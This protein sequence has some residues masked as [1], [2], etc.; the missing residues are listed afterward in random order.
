MEEMPM[1]KM[2]EAA[3]ENIKKVADANT[4]IG[5]PI[6]LP[7]GVSVIPF[8]KVSVGFASGGSDL[9]AKSETTKGPKFAGGNG[10][11][12]AVTPLG[13][14]VVSGGDVR[15]IDLNTPTSFMGNAPTDPVNRTLDSINGVLDKTPDL[16]LK[17]KDIIVEVAA[18]IKEKKAQK[19]DG[20]DKLEEA[21]SEE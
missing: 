4:V 21:S 12:L 7:D 5:T 3:L 1:K 15:V 13:F 19:E 2:I 11:G 17:I 9:E 8:S 6:T 18:K 16:A 10:A 20:A 14:I